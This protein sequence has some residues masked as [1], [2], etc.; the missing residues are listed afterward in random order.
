MKTWQRHGH[1]ASC[2]FV[3]LEA[4]LRAL[5][6]AWWYQEAIWYRGFM[7]LSYPAS[8]LNRVF[9]NCLHVPRI[10][11]FGIPME[12]HEVVIVNVTWFS[13]GAIWWFC[14]GAGTSAVWIWFA[15][16]FKRNG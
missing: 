1:V 3:V 10:Y 4:A 6:Q 7:V 16:R 9:L 12:R 14:L 5:S 15:R 8:E 13:L 2:V 11:G